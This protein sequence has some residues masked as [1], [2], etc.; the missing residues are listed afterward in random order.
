MNQILVQVLWIVGAALVSGSISAIFAGR[1]ELR[2]N[3]FLLAYVPATAALVAGYTV[4]TAIDP[5]ELFSHNWIWGLVG[6]VPAS[7]IA[8]KNVLSQSPSPRRKGAYFLIDIVW[9]GFSYGL[10]DALLLSVLPVVAVGRMLSGMAWTDG[11]AGTLG[12]GTI[13]FAASIF[14]TV[15]YHVGYP[16]YRNKRVWWTILGNGIFTLAM[17]VTGNPLAAIVPHIVMHVASMIHGR[18]TTLQLPPHYQVE[19]QAA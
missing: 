19:K 16:E 6:A 13:A 15:V 1:F 2:R 9:P 14:V 3:L 12:A 17:L 7:A 11:A 10:V 4:W 5:V 8:M 18:G